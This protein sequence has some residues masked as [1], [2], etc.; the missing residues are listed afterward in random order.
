MI[1]TIEIYGRV[2]TLEVADKLDRFG[3]FEVK[4]AIDGREQH[5]AHYNNYGEMPDQDEREEIA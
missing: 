5:R 3:Q 2:I 4:L 1:K